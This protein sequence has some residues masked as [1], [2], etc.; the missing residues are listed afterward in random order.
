M[1]LLPTPFPQRVPAG[2]GVG[3]PRAFARPEA[4]IERMP[5]AVAN[6]WDVSLTITAA[7]GPGDDDED[8]EDKGTGSGGG[9]NID[10]DDDDYGSDDDEEDDEEDP[11]WAV[12]WVA[13]AP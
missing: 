11:L 2:A 8:D 7:P 9:G 4:G 6:S 12:S 13:I 3:Y 10:P 5:L 1:T